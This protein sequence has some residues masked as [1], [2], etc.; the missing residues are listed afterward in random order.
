LATD[1]SK[2]TVSGMPTPTVSPSSGVT[3]LM[4][5]V[6]EAGWVVN[7]LDFVVVRPCGLIAV[8]RTV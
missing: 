1:R 4:A 7:V 5:M 6:C 8:A 2:V 3:S